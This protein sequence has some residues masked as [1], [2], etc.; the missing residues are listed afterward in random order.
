LRFTYPIKAIA[1]IAVLLACTTAPALADAVIVP[2]PASMGVLASGAIGLL[3][4][5]R[6]KK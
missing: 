5:S 3:L 1:S 6:W 4:V 2:E